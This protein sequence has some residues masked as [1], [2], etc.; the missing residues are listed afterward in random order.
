MADLIEMVGLNWAK[1]RQLKEYSKG[2]TRRIGLAQALIN[3]PELIVLDEPTTGL[4]PIGTREMK[5]L[6]LKLQERGQDGADVQPPAG[7]RCFFGSTTIRSP[8]Q[9]IIIYLMIECPSSAVY[10]LTNGRL[11]PVGLPHHRLFLLFLFQ[12]KIFSVLVLDPF[13]PMVC[14]SSFKILLSHVKTS[15]VSEV[16]LIGTVG[17]ESDLF[18][19]LR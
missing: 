9:S 6:I 2:M 1:R 10:P 3:D 15:A 18:L 19:L 8:F 13:K 16:N 12:E 5:D 17:Y 4:D 7:R 14:S 11:L